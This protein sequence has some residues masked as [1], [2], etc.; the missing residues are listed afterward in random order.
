LRVAD[1]GNE[2]HHAD[3]K[4]GEKRGDGHAAAQGAQAQALAVQPQRAV[5]QAQ[6]REHAPTRGAREI[7]PGREPVGGEPISAVTLPA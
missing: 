6:N 7:R 5:R 3:A 1:R 2:S 4:G